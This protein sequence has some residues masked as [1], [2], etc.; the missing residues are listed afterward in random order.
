MKIFVAGA[1]GAVGRRLIPKLLAAGHEVTGMTRR[2]EAAKALA[3]M[4]ARPVIADAYD[5]DRLCEHL[6]AVAPDVVMH[7]LTD[8]S[9]RDYAANARLRIEGTPNLVT[10][11]IAAG[12]QRIIAQSVA[13]LYRD[14]DTLAVETEAFDG[15]ASAH[16]GAAALEQ[17]VRTVPQSVILRY[18]V[19]YGPGTWYARDGA[20]SMDALRGA[21]SP[22]NAWTSFVHVDDA[23]AA[24]VAAL[25]WPSG[26][27]NIVD[28]E[29]AT[30]ADW[31]PV[32]CGAL[33]AP[34]PRLP[35]GAVGGRPVSNAAARALGWRPSFPSWRRG[36]PSTL[37]TS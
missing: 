15:R 31:A 6:T 20:L 10:A 2:S 36:L 19:L 35:T 12:A 27:Y 3:H 23:A 37:R 11:A 16:P 8:L 28:D 34:V 14:G 5:F 21:W 32:F 30:L 7:Q 25:D 22:A 4:G 18:G 29:P 13:W 33:G 24:A 17:C 1:S 26:A 9:A